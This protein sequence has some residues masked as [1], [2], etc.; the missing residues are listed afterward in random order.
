MLESHASRAILSDLVTGGITARILLVEDD[1]EMSDMLAETLREHAFD[2]AIVASAN[3]MDAYL[4]RASA[5]IVVLDVM[6]PGEDGFSICK[7]LRVASKIPIIMLTAL[8]E[9]GDRVVGLEIGA[10][11]YVTKPFRSRE[12]IIYRFAGWKLEPRARQLFNPDDV[13]VSLTGAEFDLLLAFC[14]NP[15]RVLAREQLLE[16]MHGGAAGPIARSID[17]H[18]SRV[19]KKIDPELEDS[20]FIKAVRLG[21][22]IFTPSVETN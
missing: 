5:D 14:R 18:V 2:V 19:R 13:R 4:K 1:A 8:D 17:V 11:D 9:E 12:L 6:L 15:G 16:L 3:E 10:D 20:S 21:G 22:Y 7:R